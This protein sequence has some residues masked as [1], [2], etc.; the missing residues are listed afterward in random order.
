MSGTPRPA[1]TPRRSLWWPG[2]VLG[3]AVIVVEVL[4]LGWFGDRKDVGHWVTHLLVG[5]AVALLV[6]SFW[7]KHAPRSAPHPVLAVVA[8]HLLGALP[9]LLVE[10][11]VREGRWMDVFLGSVS[12]HYAPAGN[13]TWAALAVA[14]GVTYAR[15]RPKH[16]A[17][18]H[19]GRRRRPR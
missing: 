1:G 15:S 16:L 12:A 4:L 3:P 18:R 14:A 19:S 7:V 10:A 17:R 5:A 9:D 8:A 11:G 6:L 2:P 13:L